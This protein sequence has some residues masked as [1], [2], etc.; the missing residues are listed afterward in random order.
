MNEILK[1]LEEEKEIVCE[2][3]KIDNDVMNTK[4]SYE[5][6]YDLFNSI[7]N[8]DMES[9]EINESTIFVTEG[10]VVFTLEIL[11]RINTTHSVVIF[12][13]QGNIAMNK[14]LMNKY[15]DLTNNKNVLLDDSIN[16]NKYIS[17][18]FKVFPVGEYEMISQ[19]LEDFYD[20]Q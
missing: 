20:K 7:L 19:T 1:W 3:I 10:E 15:Y 5:Y 11:R 16:Y 2:L 13:N 6:Y 8:N 12:I 18:G 14:W 9:F 4:Y 17:K